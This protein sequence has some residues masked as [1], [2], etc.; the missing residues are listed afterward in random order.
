M[1]HYERTLLLGLAAVLLSSNLNNSFAASSADN[2]GQWRGPEHNGVSRTATPP[3]PYRNLTN[4]SQT[5]HRHLTD[6]SHT[7]HGETY[8]KV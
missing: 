4:T 7:R 2:W 3:T 6:T 1:R 8:T 5:P